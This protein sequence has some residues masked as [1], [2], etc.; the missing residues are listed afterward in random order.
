M[1]EKNILIIGGGFGGVACALALASH[2][3]I[4]AKITLVSDKP[5]LE[6]TPAL[7][8]VVT[9]GSPLEVCIPLS[10]IFFGYNVTFITDTIKDVDFSE[11]KALGISGSYYSFD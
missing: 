7:Y 9:G 2:N 11:K 1:N 10:E 6:Y 8:R 4:S 3:H 5:H